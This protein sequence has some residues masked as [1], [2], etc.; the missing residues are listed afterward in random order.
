LVELVRRSANLAGRLLGPFIVHTLV[1]FD[2]CALTAAKGVVSGSV[3]SI[4]EVLVGDERL[5]PSAWDRAPGQDS[6]ITAAGHGSDLKR[7]QRRH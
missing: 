7:V 4:F 3:L 1:N 6:R 5:G 2:V